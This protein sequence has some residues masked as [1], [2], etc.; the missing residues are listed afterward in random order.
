MKIPFMAEFCDLP[1]FLKVESASLLWL[2]FVNR[3][4]VDVGVYNATNLL[5]CL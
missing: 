3:P 1:L 2:Q 4:R 5:L